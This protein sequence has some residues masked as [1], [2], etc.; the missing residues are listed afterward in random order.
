M[1]KR[2]LDNP[3]ID[4]E[5][6]SAVE[7]ILDPAQN[8]VTALVLK[9]VATGKTKELPVDGV[10]VAVGHEPATGAF[11]GKIELDAKGYV[12]TRERGRRCPAYLRRGTSRIPATARRS[13]L[14]EAAARPRSTRSSFSRGRKPLPG[15]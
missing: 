10:F 11:K 6:N 2:V 5:W 12:V 9:N 8:R 4:F 7:D 14:R 1:Q 13:P 3:K 15:W